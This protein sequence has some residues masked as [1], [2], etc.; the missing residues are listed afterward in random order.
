MMVA[1]SST[2]R[3]SI[4]RGAVVALPAEVEI[5][6]VIVNEAD[7][8]D[9]KT[10]KATV[11]EADAMDGKTIIYKFKD[12]KIIKTSKEVFILS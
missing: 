7:T 5:D 10:D 6:E 11:N 9:G 2:T 4:N 8:M 3:S 1:F 12:C